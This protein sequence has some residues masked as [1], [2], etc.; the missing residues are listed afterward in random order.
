MTEMIIAVG[1][2]ANA[3]STDGT[4][5][6]T[7]DPG[8]SVSNRVII[9]DY[10]NEKFV[11]AGYTG[12]LWESADG[13]AWTNLEPGTSGAWGQ[14]VNGLFYSEAWAKYVAAG[15]GNQIVSSPDLAVWTSHYT[16]PGF[17]FLRPAVYSPS[18]EVGVVGYTGGA[19][20]SSSDG[21][22]W[23][24]TVPVATSV[25]KG[26]W[27]EDLG[28]FFMVGDSGSIRES[29]SG[30]GGWGV[31]TIAGL[32]AIWGIG[33]S[34]SLGKLMV[35]AGT[36]ISLSPDGAT[37]SNQT[38]PI[39]AGAVVWNEALGV[40]IAVSGGSGDVA[41]SP[42]GLTG[43]WTS[44]TPTTGGGSSGGLNDIAFIGLGA[45]TGGT[46][47]GASRTWSIS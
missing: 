16:H 39:S 36:D 42:T 28:K 38:C 5:W 33:W 7:F 37:W 26:L 24:S 34:S 35:C 8:V 25:N 23:T 46:G 6:A 45:P 43:S 44:Y 21:N 14:N 9:W 18:L 22:T 17:G 32:G 10:V 20:I 4:T 11:Y 1:Q 19:L 13:V 12:E 30:T 40:W 47:G 31:S 2:S 41:T 15:E 29:A 3:R 27:V